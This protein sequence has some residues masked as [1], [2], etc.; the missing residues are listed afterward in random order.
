MPSRQKRKQA[1]EKR[2]R[3]AKLAKKKLRKRKVA[4]A[5]IKKKDAVD[6]ISVR[7]SPT[8]CRPILFLH[9]SLFQV[10]GKEARSAMNEKR[11]KKKED[12]KMQKEDKKKRGVQLGQRTGKET[13][14]FVCS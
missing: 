14:R 13:G 9:G 8:Q 4:P 11:R 6:L 10:S 5:T 3:A 7:T 12:K 2:D 1:Q